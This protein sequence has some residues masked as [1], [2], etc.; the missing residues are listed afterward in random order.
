MNDTLEKIFY[1]EA[2]KW[3]RETVFLSSFRAICSHPSHTKVMDLAK[4]DKNKI[5]ELMLYDLVNNR[6]PWFQALVKLT[7]I[8]PVK[9]QD[10]G[11]MDKIIDSWYNWGIQNGYF[12]KPHKTLLKILL[13]PILTKFGW[14]IVSNF[15]ENDNFVNYDLKTYPEHCKGP[16]KVWFKIR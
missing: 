3:S 12:T 9:T 4:I 1:E 10:A 11:K 13:N 8:N 14:I 6:R 5:I 2:E 16:F 15:D 7:G